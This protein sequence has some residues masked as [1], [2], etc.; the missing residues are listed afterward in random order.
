MSEEL[1]A[2]VRAELPEVNFSKV[3]AEGLRDLVRCDHRQLACAR[4]GHLEQRFELEDVAVGRF[5]LD[6]VDE[7]RTL[8][9]RGGTAE[10]AARVAKSIGERH[11]VTVATRVPLPR[12]TRA[13]RHAYKVR[14][15]P[16]E[17]RA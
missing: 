15:F 8:V 14:D 16:L 11:R 10:G 3:L 5:Y 4:C 17:R 12:P 6:L 2:V 13:E 7:L 1:A 9:T